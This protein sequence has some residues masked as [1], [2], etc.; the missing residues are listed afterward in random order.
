[1]INQI[2]R[3][4]TPIH[5]FQLPFPANLI[6]KLIIT[7]EQDDEVVLE[8][9]ESDVQFDGYTAKIVLTQDETLRF[10]S[11]FLVKIQLKAKTIEGNTIPSDMICAIVLEVLNKEIL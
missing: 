1:M 3:G 6:E 2:Q 9:S 7:Y 10:K 4:S 11:A 5:E 8:K